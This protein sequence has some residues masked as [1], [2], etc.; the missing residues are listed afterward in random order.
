LID[1]GRRKVAFVNGPAQYSNS[2]DRL[3]GYKA[4]LQEAEINFR[5]QLVYAGNYSRKSGFVLA[6]QIAKQIR[7]GS[8][9]AVFA[10]N[11]R[12]A[13]GLMQG[14]RELELEAGQQY[15]LVGYDDS[16]GSR[17]ISPRLSTVS[18]PFYEMG[19]LAASRLLDQA[20]EEEPDNSRPHVLPV[21]FVPRETS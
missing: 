10:A 14:L 2:A 7:D 16:D 9:D 13:I 18:V 6:E 8:V 11:D 17:I 1:R 21:S 3:L 19:K 12:M 4:A 15:A 5:Q 20:P